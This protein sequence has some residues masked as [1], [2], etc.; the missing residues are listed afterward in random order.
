MRWR[1]YWLE[2][3]QLFAFNPWT[4]NGLLVNWSPWPES[5]GGTQLVDTSPGSPDPLDDLGRGDAAL[6][7]GR[8][9]NDNAAGVHITTLRRG[10][11]GVDPW[12]ECQVNLGA[13]PGNHAPVLKLEVDHPNVATNVLIHFHAAATDPD[14]DALAYAWTFD[15][16][17]FST[18]NLPWAAK[19]FATPGDHVVRCVVSDMKGGEASANAVV[20]VGAA[21]GFRVTGRVTDTNGVPLEGVLVG[22]GV[23][24]A[25]GFIGGWTDSDGRYVLVNQSA[26]NS[27]TLNA[28]QFGCTFA[29]GTNWSNPVQPTNNQTGVDFLATPLTMVNISVDTNA[30]AETDHSAHYFTITRTGD[31]NS[32]LPVNIALAGT[33]IYSIDYTLDPDLSATNLITIPA[34]SNSVVVAFHALTDTL[35]LGSQ[36]V[37]LTLVDDLNYGAPAYALAPLASAT[38]TILDNDLPANRR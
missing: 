4:E 21:G 31:T 1:Y 22:N 18:N 32:D 5:G 9:F 37:T 12:L 19:A 7:I 16:L 38:I 13:F 8:T 33:A 30:V 20:T 34:G 29:P 10:S 36:T 25:S 2:F 24:P 3:R 26:T 17:T 14:G 6:V 28:W 27:V 15:D 23:V 11:S 35:A